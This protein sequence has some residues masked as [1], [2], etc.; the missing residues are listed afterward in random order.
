[1]R[2]LEERKYLTGTLGVAL[3]G[4]AL[5]P[6]AFA[7]LYVRQYGVNV[8]WWDSWGMVSLFEELSAGTL[9]VSDLFYVDVD[10]ELFPAFHEGGREGVAERF[11]VPAY[12][13]AG[14]VTHIPASRIQPGTR[15]LSLVVLSGDRERYYR[16]GQEVEVEFE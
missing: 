11:G 7:F 10:G 15:E 1:M 13:N 6:A 9:G 8:V 5:L 14:F 2:A 12:R 16:T 3:W 4:L